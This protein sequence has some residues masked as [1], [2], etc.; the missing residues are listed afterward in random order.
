MPFNLRKVLCLALVASSLG[1]TRDSRRLSIGFD[2]PARTFHESSPVGNGR[3]GGMLFGGI[4]KERIVL[5][6]LTLW[7][8]SRQEADRE[9][10]HEALPEIRRLLL[11]GRNPEAQALLSKHFICKGPGTSFGA[12][13]DTGPF[14]CYQVLGL[15]ELDF[16]QSTRKAQNYRR[17]LDLD[18]ATAQVR[19]CLGGVNYTR[20]L[21][22]SAPDHALVLRLRADKPGHLNFLTSLSREH[23]GI[24]SAEDSDGLL[25]GGQMASGQAGVEGLRFQ[26][27]LRVRAEGGRV[28]VSPEG[29]R[30][31]RANQVTLYLTAGTNYADPDFAHTVAA[32]LDAVVRKPFTQVQA[33]HRKEFRSFFRRV[34]LDLGSG[35][36][37]PMPQRLAAAQRTPDPA[38]AAL[39]FQFGRYL[40]ISSS[41]PD[42]PLPANLQGLWAEEYQ[43]PWNGDYHVNVNLQM[44]Y[45]PAEITNLGDCQRPLLRYIESLVK[46]GTRT[47]LAY[48][49]ARGW[50]VHVVSNPWG[51]TSPGEG[52]DWGSTVSG[53]PWLCQHL[54]NH[55]AFHPDKAFLEWA[56]PILK[57]SAEFG[58]ASL[59]EEPTHHWLVTA[60]SNSPENTFRLADG[61]TANTCMGPTMDE[62]IYRELFTNTLQAA[63]LLGRDEDFAKRLETARER[64]APT[65]IGRHGQIQEWLED[66][67]EVDP[68]HRHVSQLYGLHPGDQITPRGTP[69]LARAARTT[70][71][72]RGDTSTGWSMAWKMA[73]WARLGDGDRAAKLLGD[74][75]KPSDGHTGGTYPNLF[76][77][78][79]PFQIDG[80]FGACAAIA[81][82]LLQSHAGEIELLPAL[83]KLWSE[84]HVKGLRTQ[85]GYEVDLDWKGGRLQRASLRASQDGVCK[86][87]YGQTR[88]EFRL[89]AGEMV[90][91]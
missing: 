85:G 50:A 1:F 55:Y 5:N 45:W 53:G 36:S 58:L 67:D 11:E 79:P 76:C 44:N 62:Q 35:S 89:K 82:M 41:R 87:R 28:A 46:P 56:Y 68:H 71:E 38:L 7:S 81:E 80:N 22:I 40:L 37:L 25:L 34:S 86:V 14:G 91:W 65:Q 75:L 63:R 17:E 72:R 2:Q 9:D 6:E 61:R 29:L 47:A 84:G 19:Y 74:L 8:G 12:A 49:G 15:L 16:G 42:S 54:W 33:D 57:G 21:F 30:V 43:T 69:E 10:A 32:Q 51:F 77:A 24:V 27:R 4:A 48:Y 23:R 78:H 88:R 13:G 66:Y 26:A 18:S 59:V 52:A 83:P 20:E 31:S 90:R 64:L 39:Y 70:L 60:P 73:F 3:L